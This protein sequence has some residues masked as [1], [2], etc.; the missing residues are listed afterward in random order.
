MQ[1]KTQ[2][3]GLLDELKCFAKGIRSG[4]WPIPLWQQLQVSRVAFEIEEMIHN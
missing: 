1:T 3:K 4:E 2:D